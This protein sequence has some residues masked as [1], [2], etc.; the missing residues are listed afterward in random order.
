MDSIHPGPV[1]YEFRSA[2]FCSI[3][4]PL[5]SGPGVRLSFGWST[6][7]PGL[8]TWLDDDGDQGD[9]LLP[10]RVGHLQLEGVVPLLHGG[11]LQGG[12]AHPL[13]TQ[14]EPVGPRYSV[15][16]Q[17]SKVNIPFITL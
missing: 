7:C 11:Q 12:R 16:G 9:V 8:P 1:L 14:R 3:G 10:G 4:V 5:Y 6:G 2:V 15:P 17:R 13:H